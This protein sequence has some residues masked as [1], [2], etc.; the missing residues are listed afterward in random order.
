MIA[1]DMEAELCLFWR[2]SRNRAA[3]R[4]AAND[5]AHR[6]MLAEMLAEIDDDLDAMAQHSEWP[7]LRQ[8]ASRLLCPALRAT[9]L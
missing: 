9:A 5:L 8:A 3:L 7:Q 4:L 1:K 6:E 2:L